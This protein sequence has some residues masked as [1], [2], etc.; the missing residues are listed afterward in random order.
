[1]TNLDDI[2]LLTSGS[3]MLLDYSTNSSN[4][5]KLAD[6]AVDCWRLKKIVNK[7]VQQIN[8]KDYRRLN[9]SINRI[10][11]HLNDCEIEI[12]DYEKRAYN[13]GMNVDLISVEQV[14][15]IR[16]AIIFETYEPVIKYQGKTFRKSKV[17]V[18]EPVDAKHQKKVLTKTADCVQ[19]IVK[20]IKKKIRQNLKNKKRVKKGKT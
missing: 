5:D 4:I 16:E 15:D 14:A 17:I 10:E 18:H 12:E 20:P 11:S 19:K 2:A 7:L 9:N 3:G 8:E 13:E 6:I 1:M